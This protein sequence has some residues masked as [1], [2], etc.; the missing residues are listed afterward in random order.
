MYMYMYA[1]YNVCITVNKFGY[2]FKILC[3]ANV[4]FT[5]WVTHLILFINCS[6]VHVHV[7]VC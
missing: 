1:K 5:N 6:T 4:A 3:A 2:L 7:H